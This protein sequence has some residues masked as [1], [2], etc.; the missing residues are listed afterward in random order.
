MNLSEHRPCNR[1]AVVVLAAGASRRMA[2]SKA[3]LE[4]GDRPA[5]SHLVQTFQQ[6]DH[7]QRTIVVTGHEPHPIHEALRKLDVT[8]VHNPDYDGGGMLSSVKLGAKCAA[9]NSDAFFLGLLDQPVVRASTLAAMAQAWFRT[10]SVIVVPAHDGKHGHPILIN[11]DFVDE[12]VSQPPDAT[13]R[14]FVTQHRQETAVVEVND[15]GILTS[16]DTPADYQLV[17]NLWRTLTCPTVS[18]DPA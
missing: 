18:A 8:F 17:L 11:S 15:P 3:L 2:R 12:I 6:L 5:I 10:N 4:I 7:V 14:D 9:G 16:L 13:L 1:L